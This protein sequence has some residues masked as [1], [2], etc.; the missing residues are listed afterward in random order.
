MTPFV[1]RLLD[2]SLHGFRTRHS[3]LT[4]AAGDRVDFAF[5]GGS[6]A[7]RVMWTRILDSE[8]ETGFN[9]LRSA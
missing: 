2:L 4:L 8:A 9:I 6:G 3:C 7:A 5:D 1:G